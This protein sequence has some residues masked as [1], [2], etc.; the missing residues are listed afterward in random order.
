MRNDG[1]ENSEPEDV[2]RRASAPVWAEE[3]HD[4][5]AVPPQFA[6]LGKGTISNHL[7]YRCLLQASLALPAKDESVQLLARHVVLPT[8]R[9]AAIS[10]IVPP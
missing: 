4:C 10:R 2:L 8:Q 1:Y 9:L 7:V 5:A 3:N 6:D